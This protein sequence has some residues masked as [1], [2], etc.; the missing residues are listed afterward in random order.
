MACVKMVNSR[1]RSENDGLPRGRLDGYSTLGGF[2]SLHNFH[3]RM[4]A[5]NFTRVKSGSCARKIGGS[6]LGVS[7][8]NKRSKV[9]LSLR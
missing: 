3:V 8:A 4:H 1:L 7:S 6:G 5:L 9:T 2:P